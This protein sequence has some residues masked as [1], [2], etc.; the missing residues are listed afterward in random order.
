MTT[1]TFLLSKD[2]LTEHGGDI[3]LS[4]LVMRLAAEAFDVSAICLSSSSETLDTELASTGV[5]LTRVVKPAVD[6]RSLLTRAIRRR[7]S[8]VHVR[9]DTPELAA[10]IERTDAEVFVAE[11][12]YMGESF[13]RTRHYRDRRFVVNTVNTESEVWRATRGVLGR[14]EAPRLV[15]DELRV[16]RA[17]DAVGTYDA[18]EAQWYVQQG[19]SGARWID[20]TMEPIDQLDLSATSRRLVFLGTRDWPPNQEAFLEALRL[21]PAIS[22]GIAGAEL[23]VIGAKKPGAPDVALP[24]GVRDL[25]FVDDLRGM[26]A[27][28]RALIAPVRT[29]GGVRV[30]ILDAA[31]MGLP[32]IATSAAVGSLGS[33][34]GLRTFDDD[35]EFVDEC[36]RFLLESA[37]SAAAG[38]D[39]YQRN[40][41]HWR[42]RRPHEAVT[43]L[44]SGR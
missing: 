37:V 28:C 18:D 11:H 24:D 42:Q 38:T 16:A 30:K 34:F 36:R 15:R 22:D 41:D 20:L 7:R 17:A 29:G 21:W 40:A 33:L 3:A 31:R 4:R 12:N 26:L 5:R 43:G 13:L 6:A 39:L 44:L 27:T 19:V 23:V 32:V 2:P 1:V 14:I 9:F 10:A 8:L 35:T 25:G